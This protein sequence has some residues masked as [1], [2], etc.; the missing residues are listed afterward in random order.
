MCLGSWRNRQR[1]RLLIC[2]GL[3]SNPSDPTEESFVIRHSRMTNDQRRVTKLEGQAKGRWQPSRKRPSS[4]ALRVQL[5]LLPLVYRIG[6][7]L[8]VGCLALNEVMKV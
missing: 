5:P 4:N 6:G 3:G 2:E 7:R 1:S 8:T